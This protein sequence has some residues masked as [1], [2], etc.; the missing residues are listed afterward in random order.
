MKNQNNKITAV[1]FVVA[2]ALAPMVKAVPE[3]QGGPSSISSRNAPTAR[4]PASVVRPQLTPALLAA[5]DG[6]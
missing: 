3:P 2:L 4:P 5:G 1:L 6:R